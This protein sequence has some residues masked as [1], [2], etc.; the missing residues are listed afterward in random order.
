MTIRSVKLFKEML[1]SG[2]QAV[3]VADLREVVRAAPLFSPMTP[4]GK[5]MRVKMTS[6]GKYGWFSDRKGYRYEPRHPEGM[7]WPP[8][9]D[10]VLKVW[11]DVA[12]TDRAPDC[13]LVNY[14]TDTAKMGLHQDKDEA[15]FG[16]PVVSISLGDD[17]LFR[18]GNLTR[19][20]KTESVWLSSGDVVVMG[21]DA[22][23]VYH[24]IDRV[25]AGTSTL[26]DGGGRINLTLRVVDP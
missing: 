2:D 8:I 14:Y 4:Y 1:T 15:D 5:P 12:G 7:A 16:Y 22:R 18:I 25:K 3:M 24:G 19:G 21:D 9:P 23:L 10:S 6:A 11:H 13:C 20:G 17:A 26:L